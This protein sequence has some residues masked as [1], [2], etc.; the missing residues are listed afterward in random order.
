MIKL[1]HG[2]NTKSFISILS[3]GF[4]FLI[5]TSYFI[6]DVRSQDFFG[7]FSRRM[8]NMTY[9]NKCETAPVI[10]GNKDACWFD[11][12]V[13]KT[14]LETD[15]G[16]FY[17]Y[18]LYDDNYL[19]LMFDVLM[20]VE[21]QIEYFKLYFN[22]TALNQTIY[23]YENGTPVFQTGNFQRPDGFT[24]PEG[25]NPPSGNF[26]LP[27][28]YEPGQ[29]GQF[30]RQF[31]QNITQIEESIN[32]KKIIT[33]QYAQNLSNINI[34][35]TD[36]Y[37]DNDTGLLV[38]DEDAM[39]DYRVGFKCSNDWKDKVVEIAIPLNPT[40]SSKDPQ[41]IEGFYYRFIFVYNTTSEIGIIASPIN[42]HIGPPVYEIVYLEKPPN[43]YYILIIIVSLFLASL[44]IYIYKTKLLT[45]AK[46]FRTI[47]KSNIELLQEQYLEMVRLEDEHQEKL[48]RRDD[49]YYYKWLKK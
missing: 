9:V 36:Y 39:S 32:D 17:L 1:S 24:P 19:Y 33:I 27:E 5:I 42:I 45:P 16:Y 37:H 29:G 4:I 22:S 47:L 25:F 7:G 21:G 49:I 18:S 31:E 2:R 12:N 44:G 15:R 23:V 14:T 3:I 46:N 11:D 26:T 34:N 30:S 8:N 10:D 43:L 13:N 48:E 35:L 41:F 40:Y 20:P 6:N 38:E 28:G